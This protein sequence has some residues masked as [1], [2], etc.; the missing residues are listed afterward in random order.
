M[1]SEFGFRWLL[2]VVGCQDV[3]S[4]RLDVFFNTTYVDLWVVVLWWVGRAV[5]IK[6]PQPGCGCITL[7]LV[8]VTSEEDVC[9]QSGFYPPAVM[10]MPFSSLLCPWVIIILWSTLWMIKLNRTMTRWKWS[11]SWWWVTRP[12]WSVNRVCQSVWVVCVCSAHGYASSRRSGGCVKW[13]WN[14]HE[15]FMVIICE[16]SS[17]VQNSD[18]RSQ[19]W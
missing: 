12:A 6:G 18:W 15:S 13:T 10:E 2:Y 17:P 8:F 9:E 11:R 3:Y 7:S 1:S 14:G 19:W 4:G 16:L 5:R